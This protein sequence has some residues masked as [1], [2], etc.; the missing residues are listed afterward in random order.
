MGWGGA[1]AVC[2][3]L[4]IRGKHWKAVSGEISCRVES[5][6]GKSLSPRLFANSR[7]PSSA[8]SFSV[9]TEAV[10][11]QSHEKENYHQWFSWTRQ[12]FFRQRLHHGGLAPALASALSSPGGTQV[13]VE[14]EEVWHGGVQGW[15]LR[16]SDQ[17]AWQ[18]PRLRHQLP[19]WWWHKVCIFVVKSIY[20]GALLTQACPLP[21]CGTWARQDGSSLAG[22]VECQSHK[23]IHK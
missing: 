7:Q 21:S 15:G 4:S 18:W 8:E 22:K 2:C 3:L 13:V 14:V 17:P 19:P 16:G 1:A 5:G 9:Q 12:E 20:S 11:R 10:K 23:S 6:K